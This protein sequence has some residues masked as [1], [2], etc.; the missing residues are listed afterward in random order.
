MNARRGGESPNCKVSGSDDDP[1]QGQGVSIERGRERRRCRSFK[2]KNR[3]QSSAPV[4]REGG[5]QSKLG[6]TQKKDRNADGQRE[7][8]GTGG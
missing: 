3:E 1:D 4:D 2:R 5:L 8:R 7:K 6:P